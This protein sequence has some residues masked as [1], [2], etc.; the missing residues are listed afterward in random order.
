MADDKNFD[1]IPEKKSWLAKNMAYLVAWYVLLLYG[2]VTLALVGT[3]IKAMIEEKVLGD[4]TVLMSIWGAV[5]G[6]GSIPINYYL[7]SSQGSN[8][9]QKTLDKMTTP[10]PTPGVVTKI[11][12]TDTIADPTKP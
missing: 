11:E 4:L 1:A 7:G 8:E 10:T 9:K 12:K 6:V 3:C 5:S 2:A